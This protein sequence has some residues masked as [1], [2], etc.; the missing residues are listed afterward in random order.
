MILLNTVEL[1]IKT[2]EDT[3]DRDTDAA[4][5][6]PTVFLFPLKYEESEL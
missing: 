4:L 3:R 1:A 5:C 2:K 6:C